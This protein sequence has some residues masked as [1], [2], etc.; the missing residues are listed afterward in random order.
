MFL[1][2]LLA[3]CITVLTFDD[4]EAVGNVTGAQ[5]WKSSGAEQKDEAVHA[6]RQAGEQRDASQGF[7]KVEEVAGKVTGCEGMQKEGEQSK[8]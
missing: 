8:K 6:M 7:G 4:Q 1:T 5:D 2:S 3:C